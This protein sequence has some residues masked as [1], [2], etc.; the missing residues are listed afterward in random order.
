MNALFAAALAV[1]TIMEQEQIPFCII[2]GLAV[3]R[4][5]EIRVTRD[6]DLTAL[7]GFAATAACAARIAARLTPRRDDAVAFAL[8]HRVLLVA[9]PNGVAVDISLGALPYEEHLVQ[10]ASC[11]AFAPDCSVRTCSAEDLVVLKAFA[12]RDRDWADI[13]GVLARQGAAL[14]WSYILPALEDLCALRDDTLTVPRLLRLRAQ[15]LGP[16]P[17]AEETASHD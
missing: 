6:V 14:D 5:G 9:A 8:K 1:H 4:W 17:H 16:S 13:A 2:G 15:E 7:T 3:I 11:F 12:G 10:R